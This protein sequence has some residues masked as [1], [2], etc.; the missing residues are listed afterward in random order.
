LKIGQLLQN[1]DGPL[2]IADLINK[3]FRSTEPRDFRI[4]AA[5]V[6]GPDAEC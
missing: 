1:P 4:V 3:L 5:T 6:R 2:N